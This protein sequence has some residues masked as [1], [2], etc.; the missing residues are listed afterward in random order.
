MDNLLIQ[1]AQLGGTVFV[2]LAF[3]YYLTKRDKEWTTLLS[4]EMDSQIKLSRSLQKLTDII[5]RNTSAV[6]KN[7]NNQ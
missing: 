4:K 2:T 7:T 6:V 1:S 3:L 5:K